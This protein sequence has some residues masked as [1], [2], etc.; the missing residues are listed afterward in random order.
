MKNKIPSKVHPSFSVRELCAS[1]KHTTARP[2]GQCLCGVFWV[3][4]EVSR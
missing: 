3:G 2:D 1:N 4:V